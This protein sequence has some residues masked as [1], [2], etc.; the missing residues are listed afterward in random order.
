MKRNTIISTLCGVALV[1][2]LAACASQAQPAE[3]EQPVAVE[4]DAK[5]E[6]ATDIEAVAEEAPE[7][8]EATTTT[9]ASSGTGILSADDLLTERDLEQTADLTDATYLTLADGQDLS[10]TEEGVYVVS[11]TATN[12]TIR[13]EA[14]DAAKV[15][16][17]LD[18]V[19]ITNESTPAIYVT[20]ADKVFVTTTD[21]DNALSVTG[22]FV[23]D[24]ETNLDAVIFSR[25]DLVLN[26]VGT[27]TVS[28]TDN[29]VSS[30][31]DLK[32]TGGTLVITCT[33]DALEAND[34][35]VVA[36]GDIQ[37]TAQEDG[38]HAENEDDATGYVYICGGTL[39]IQAGD[40]A[41]HGTEIAQVDDGTLTL[42]A[43]E[44]IE[45]TYV[46]VN[47]GDISVE[48]SD[49]G[50]NASAKSSYSTPTVE[51]NGGTITI[52]MG[53]GDTDAIDSN[54][55]IYV[56]GGSIDISAQSAF[57][58]ELGAELNGGTVKVNGEQV[59]AITGAMMG[60]MGGPM[61][62]GQ[63]GEFGGQPGGGP[64]GDGEMPSDMGGQGGPM[65]GPGN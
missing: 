18:G 32:V 65:G 30:K 5:V 34:S 19:T 22:T 6:D 57:D 33:S 14:D 40:D 45:A 15:Q 44:C 39:D 9:V 52:V 38:I 3:A 48:A 58:Y 62:G 29:G 56:N 21:S 37:I 55:Y 24:G 51:I 35:V 28:S 46:Q 17:V 12:A 47:G 61:G 7:Q 64:M 59:T 11:G 10:I 23:A 2:S 16:I 49:D 13:V 1:T 42:V 41:I 4:Q 50:I 60:G 54:G 20:S 43:G 31:D 27:L 26:G 63:Q 25:S 36:G 8:T 53:A